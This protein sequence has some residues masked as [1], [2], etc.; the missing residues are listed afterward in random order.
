MDDTNKNTQKEKE[1][2]DF[3]NMPGKHPEKNPNKTEQNID[4]LSEL[5][6]SGKTDNTEKN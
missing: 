5:N 6:D 3:Q 2:Q 1:S 4:K